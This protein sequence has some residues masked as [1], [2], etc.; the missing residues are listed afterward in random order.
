MR[1]GETEIRQCV[2]GETEIRQS[3][4]DSP[5]SGGSENGGWK[6]RRRDVLSAS[7]ATFHSYT[8]VTLGRWSYCGK[9]PKR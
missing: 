9:P 4:Q 3:P 1:L 2:L 8:R 5:E 7:L 6:S